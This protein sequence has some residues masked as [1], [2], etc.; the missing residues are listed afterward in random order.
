MFSS[1]R[2]DQQPH[3]ST[4]DRES[5]KRKRDDG[6]SASPHSTSSRAQRRTPPISQ[7][8]TETLPPITNGQP[9]GAPYTTQEPNN[10][11]SKPAYMNPT[12]NHW[13]P[14]R[15]SMDE[16]STETR[17]MEVLGRDAPQSQPNGSHQLHTMNGNPAPPNHP[18]TPSAGDNQQLPNQPIQ[19]LPGM[20]APNLQKQRKR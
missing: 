20:S 19:T 15:Q 9:S 16:T 10:S 2:P 12:E 18:L 3:F 8:H 17:L 6:E 7:S 13:Q 11:I 4:E 14:Q 1:S 5:R